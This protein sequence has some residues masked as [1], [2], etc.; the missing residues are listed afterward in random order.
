VTKRAFPELLEKPNVSKS[1][2]TKA[3]LFFV[4]RGDRQAIARAAGSYRGRFGDL[5]PR[6][7]AMIDVRLA[8]LDRLVAARTRVGLSG[9]ERTREIAVPEF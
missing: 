5:E 7:S 2:A 8:E 6:L 1:A 3:L 4:Q 9:P